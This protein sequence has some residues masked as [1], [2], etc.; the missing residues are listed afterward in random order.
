[1]KLKL[2][3]LFYFYVFSYVFLCTCKWSWIHLF[4]I[5]ISHRKKHTPKLCLFCVKF[6]LFLLFVVCCCCCFFLVLHKCK[7]NALRV[8]KHYVVFKM[9]LYPNSFRRRDR[10][11][12]VFLLVLKWQ[13]GLYSRLL[14][15]VWRSFSC[16]MCLRN[17][18][19]L[20]CNQLCLFP[21][22]INHQT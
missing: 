13:I 6:I 12:K 8:F 15:G 16:Y 1:M 4:L 22:F 10:D 9:L 18:N 7:T 20:Y 17:A 19:N 14:D 5:H 21:L 11:E 3:F 2:Q